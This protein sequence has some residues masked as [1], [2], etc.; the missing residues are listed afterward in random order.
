MACKFHKGYL[1]YT[2]Y[3]LVSNNQN[4]SGKRVNVKSVSGVRIPLTPQSKALKINKLA[5]IFNAFFFSL[6]HTFLPLVCTILHNF[7]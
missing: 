6:K 4:T 1:Y 3:Q 5:N 2:D 7:A